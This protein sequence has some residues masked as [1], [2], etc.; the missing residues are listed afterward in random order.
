[1]I[2]NIPRKKQAILLECKDPAVEL[3][4]VFKRLIKISIDNKMVALTKENTDIRPRQEELKRL[5]D[6]KKQVLEIKQD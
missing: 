4:H 2:P 5:L 6:I 3:N 1:M